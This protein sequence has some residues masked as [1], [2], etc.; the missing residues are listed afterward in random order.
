MDTLRTKTQLA[1]LLATLI[2]GTQKHSSSG[3]L[4]LEGQ[5][6]T[7]QALIEA[8]QKLGDALAKIDAAH[9]T[10]HG[11]IV[12][13]SQIRATIQPLAAAYRDYLLLVYRNAP[14]V[15]ADYGLAPRKKRTP[16]TTAQQAVAVAKRKATRT[17]RNTMGTKQ[18]HPFQRW[19]AASP[20]KSTR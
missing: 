12:Q 1:T 9:A 13:A 19:R 18:M 16:L 15:L 10:R 3:P 20:G 17:A 4:T 5:S 2:V 14:A 11:A 8:F 7:P 6:Y